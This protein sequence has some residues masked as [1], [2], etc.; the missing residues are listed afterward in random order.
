[1]MRVLVTAATKLDQDG[2]HI[3]ELGVR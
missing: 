3:L 2:G 1:M